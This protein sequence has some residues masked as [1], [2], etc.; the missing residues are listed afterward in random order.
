MG[1]GPWYVARIEPQQ[2]RL[3]VAREGDAQR[4]EFHVDRTN[5]FVDPPR[6]SLPCTV[7]IR[8]Q[9]DDSP[10]TVEPEE[11]S[12]RVTLQRARIVTPGQSAVFYDGDIVLGGGIIL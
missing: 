8:Y 10:C 3:V 4:R 11:S 12:Y 9:V 5:W 7:K 6:P 1:N 2:N